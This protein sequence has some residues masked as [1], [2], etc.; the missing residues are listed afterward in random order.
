MNNDTDVVPDGIVTVFTL[1]ITNSNRI[2]S[3]I[4]EE[5]PS[6]LVAVILTLI[7]VLLS[8]GIVW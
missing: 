6:E 2:E 1:P 3:E 4:A 7:D 8:L 5:D